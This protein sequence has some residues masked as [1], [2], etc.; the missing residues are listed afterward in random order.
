VPEPAP[1][2]ANGTAVDP[3]SAMLGLEAELWQA[4]AEMEVAAVA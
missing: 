1:P 4:A 2:S 3:S